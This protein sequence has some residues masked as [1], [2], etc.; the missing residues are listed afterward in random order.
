M[1]RAEVV[2]LIGRD[3]AKA[4]ALNHSLGIECGFRDGD[5]LLRSKEVDALVLAVPP[6]ELSRLAIAAFSYDKHVL[7]EKPLGVSLAEAESVVHA[8]RQSACIGMVNFCYRLV[9]EIRELKARMADGLCGQINHIRVDWVL[10]NRLNPTLTYH[11]KGQRELG[12]GV[13]QN[14]GVHVLDYLFWNETEVDVL[15]AVQATA[16]R[17]RPDAAGQLHPVSGDESTSAL[18]RMRGIPVAL[19][20]SLVTRPAT[21]HRIHVCGC[22]GTLALSNDDPNSPAGPFR[23]QY[24]D[25][26]QGMRILGEGQPNQTLAKLFIRT[27]EGFVDAIQGGGD[28]E[29]SLSA[30]LKVSRLVQRTQ[31]AAAESGLVFSA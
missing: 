28:R 13:L 6:V 2:G 5:S 30:A 26:R 17:R 19:H 15:G 4:A 7:C 29:P 3:T 8:W 21:G 25:G 22:E 14:F 16:I 1:D 10:S 23:L 12:G 24:D 31:S 18:F 11:W 9:P 27:L 20:L